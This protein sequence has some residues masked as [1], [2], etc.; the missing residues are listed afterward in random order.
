MTSP[1]TTAP[2][3]ATI[4]HNPS[5]LGPGPVPEPNTHAHV[6]QEH[7]APSFQ[8]APVP[9]APTPPSAPTPL[10]V[11]SESEIYGPDRLFGPPLVSGDAD[12]SSLTNTGTRFD[13]PHYM[14]M[15]VWRD[16]ASP[17]DFKDE[18]TR[19]A[20][21]VTPGV[22]DGPYIRYALD[23]LTQV[24]DNG[25]G[26]PSGYLPSESDES[27]RQTYHFT[28]T[29]VPSP[30]VPSSVHLPPGTNTG[31]RTPRFWSLMPSPAPIASPTA[32]EE[33]QER[34]RKRQE[35]GNERSGNRWNE[36]LAAAAAVGNHHHHNPP[37]PMDPQGMRS[38]LKE[39]ISFEGWVPKSQVHGLPR[40]QGY[41]QAQPDLVVT[42]PEMGLHNARGALRAASPLTLKPWILRSQSLLLLA[43]LCMLMIAAII[44]CAVYSTNNL[45]FTPYSGTI[46]GGQYFL[47]RML[48]QLLAMILL[49]YAQCVITAAF[50]VLPFSAM[51]SDNRHERKGAVFLPLYP[52][53][54]LWPQLGGSWNIWIPI[55]NVW[56]LNF[57]IPLQSSLF[58]V[59][60]VDGTWTW[61]TVQGVAWT[62]VALYVSFILS[63]AVLFVFWRKRRT[64]MMQQWGIRTL[65][66]II[67]LISQSN[68]LSQYRGLESA[69]SRRSMMQKIGGSAERLGLWFA[70]EA[71]EIGTWYGI[72]VPLGEKAFESEKLGVQAWASRGRQPS[73]GSVDR[74]GNQ[75]SDYPY[76]PWCFRSGQI[77]SFALACSLLLIALIVVSFLPL[78]DIRNGFLPLL[79]AAPDAGAFSA[80]NFLYSFL[81]S[82]IGLALFLMFQPLDLTLRILTPWGELTHPEGSRAETSLLVDYSVCLPL[83]ST[84]KAMRNHHWRVALVSLL[85]FLFALL[86]V[87]GG[88]MF[89]AL[90]PPGTDV[91]MF[92]NVPAFAIALA[93][94]IL[95][96]FGLFCLIPNRSQ[97][98]LPH[99]VTCLAEIISFCCDDQ[100]REDDAFDWKMLLTPRDLANRLDVSKYRPRQSRWMFSAGRTSDERLSIRRC[101]KYTVSPKKLRTW[102]KRAKGHLISAPLPYDN[103]FLFNR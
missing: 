97:F 32:E 84:F 29:T 61:A 56:L 47:F 90:T 40:T 53:S 71:P 55:F 50:W 102:D 103:S 83:E 5:H 22:D 69:T 93:L 81:P 96:V 7:T 15:S 9:Y 68:S 35:D 82:L 21:M 98:R 67:F 8:Q 41:W 48:P 76:L 24:R 70:P 28:P 89:L 51:A 3:Q 33:L 65:A 36:V 34:R 23:A 43:T 101:T 80:A 94:L 27:H 13:Q 60:L 79:S 45:G 91:R 72:G 57:T 6:H 49:I 54:F 38:P 17:G 4:V 95:Y 63:L 37:Y 59:I 20:S 42:D 44:F 85:S 46:Y 25:R 87:L 10:S 74:P 86:P 58:T 88:G 18:L 31:A 64:G 16:G 11:S 92:P 1:T 14:P 99:A 73:V 30:L 77:V 52:K 62:L 39:A 19:A 2:S 26:A 78:T 66:D 12:R 100:L 75:G